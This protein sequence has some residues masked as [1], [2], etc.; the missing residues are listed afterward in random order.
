MNRD[1]VVNS[2]WMATQTVNRQT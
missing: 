1:H 2:Y